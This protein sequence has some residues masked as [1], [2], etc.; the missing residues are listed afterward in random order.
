M[1]LIDEKIY[2]LSACPHCGGNNM[3]VPAEGSRRHGLCPDCG[4]NPR[5]AITV[6]AAG[7]IHVTYVLEH[8]GRGLVK[9]PI[10][11]EPAQAA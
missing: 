6:D 3:P 7:E 2:H 8:Q 5:A 11:L 4:A 9:R 1:P 10:Y